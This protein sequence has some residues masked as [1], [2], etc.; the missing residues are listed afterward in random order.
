[1]ETIC[2]KCQ[3]LFLGKLE[4]YFNI[5]SAENLKLCESNILSDKLKEN[6]S[7]YFASSDKS[8]MQCQ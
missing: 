2:M 1:M 6:S 3:T 8:D 5:A 4:K 7:N